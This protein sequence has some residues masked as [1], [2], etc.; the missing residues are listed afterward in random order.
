MPG[1][2]SLAS[3]RPCFANLMVEIIVGTY[4]AS[5]YLE[6]HAQQ[7]LFVPPIHR[8][9]LAIASPSPR[10]RHPTRPPTR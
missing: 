8:H 6:P 7:T 1:G 3:F 10:H 5:M 9:R 2:A 4:P